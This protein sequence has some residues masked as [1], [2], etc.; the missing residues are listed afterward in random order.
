MARVWIAVG[1]AAVAAFALFAWRRSK[2]KPAAPPNAEPPITF[3]R[4]RCGGSPDVT[5]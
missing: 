5:D 4:G 1:I 2:T 3:R